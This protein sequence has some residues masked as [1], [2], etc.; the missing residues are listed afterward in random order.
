MLSVLSL[1]I[2]APNFA[3]PKYYPP[4]MSNVLDHDYR[5][6]ATTRFLLNIKEM[7]DILAFQEVT[8]GQQAQSCGCTYDEY[9]HLK[10]LLDDEFFS[11][12]YSHDK[13]YWNDYGGYVPN[14]NALFFRRS[15]FSE[16]EWS[17]IPLH[18]GNHAILGE[19]THLPTM[20]KLR[21]LNI[22]LD[23]EYEA[24][25]RRELSNALRNI[26]PNTEYIDIITGDFNMES[27]DSCY[28]LIRQTGF[29]GFDHKT[30]TFSFMMDRPID[31]IVYRDLC[32]CNIIPIMSKCKVLDAGLWDKFP[33]LDIIDIFAGARLKAC[34][35]LYGSDHIP[36]IAVFILS[37]AIMTCEL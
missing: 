35:D 22:H 11:M 16:P 21:V 7:Y 9:T 27:S 33:R 28:D 36:V 17:D 1:N 6:Q 18:T 10:E 29:R 24:N 23:S 12:F 26:Q 30:P 31:H 4:G 14:G 32:G 25:R 2:L 13:H 3:L 8:H 34:I 37:P 5:R 20:R 19:V 15:T